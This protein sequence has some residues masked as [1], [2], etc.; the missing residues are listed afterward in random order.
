MRVSIDK[1]GRM[2]IPKQLRD[3]LGLT[4]GVKLEAVVEHGQFVATPVGPEVILVD[5]GGRLVA[6][7]REPT[8]PMEHDE[9]LHL[10]DEERRWPHRL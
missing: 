5:E 3:E 6:A 7:T 9:L 10:I 4:P 8:E 1:I 2:V